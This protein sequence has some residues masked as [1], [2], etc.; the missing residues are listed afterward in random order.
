MRTAPQPMDKAALAVAVFERTGIALDK[1]DPAFAIV[2]LARLAF[3]DATEIVTD[4]FAERLNGLPSRIHETG[5]AAAAEIAAQGVGGVVEMLRKSR[6]T[7]EA[8]CLR[9]QRLLRD[10][11]EKSGDLLARQLRDALWA[12]QAPQGQL[13]GWTGRTILAGAIVA[14]LAGTI[15]GVTAL[16]LTRT[17]ASQDA[18][19]Q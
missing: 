14:I 19:R 17:L 15:G 2:E 13:S 7:I 8:D 3:A 6:E 1:D 9:A 18:A 16:A 11:T 12:A 5:A 10:Q 4:R